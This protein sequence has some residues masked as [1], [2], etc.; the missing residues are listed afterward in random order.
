MSTADVPAPKQY[1]GVMVSSTFADLQKQREV[2]RRIIIAHGL[3]PIAMEHDSAKPEGDVLNS[4]LAMVRDCAAY[5]GIVGHTYGQIPVSSVRNPDRLS[6][7][8]LEFNFALSLK[9]P[10]LLFIMSDQHDVKPSDIERE[11]ETIQK[12]ERFRE[13]A[14]RSDAEPSMPRVYKVFSD[15][16]EFEAAAAQS[17]ASLRLYLDSAAGSNV[18]SPSPSEAESHAAPALDPIPRPPALYSEPAYI[19]SHKFVGRQNQIET[20]S[21]WAMPADSHAVLLFEAI[22]GA[23]KSMLTWE[24]T[25]RYAPGVR[26]DWAGYF[27]YSFY[28]RGATMVDFCRRGL[29]YMTGQNRADFRE[30]NVA[31][32][33]RLLLH[34]L[35]ARPWLVILD[36]LE[37][38]L[39]AYHR[40]DAAQVLDERA[41][42][43]DTI[44]RR[45]PCAATNPED[46]DLLRALASAGPSKLLLTSRLVPRALLNNSGQSIPGVVRERL[47]G[48]RPADAEALIRA[49]G[50]RGTS[51][52]IQHFLKSHCDCH[53]LVVGVLA[54]IINDYLPDRGHFNAWVDDPAYGGRLNLAALDLIQKRN[55]ILKAAL[56]ALSE[57][58][59]QLLSTLALLS[60]AVDYSTLCALNPHLPPAPEEVPVPVAPSRSATWRHLEDRT[61][62]RLE[63]EYEMFMLRRKEYE[64]SHASHL[65]ASSA[66]LEELTKT[67]S[68]LERR[69]LLQ[70]DTS[71]RRYDLH[72]VVRGIAA[73]GLGQEEKATYGQRVVD[74]FSQ[75]AQNP[76]ELAS[77][78]DDFEG[79]RHIV[80]TFFH[81][82][83]M[84]DA[85]NFIANSRFIG[86]MNFRFEAHNEILSLL[87]PFFVAG[88]SVM[89]PCLEEA[90]GTYFARRAAVSL[91][92][93]GALDDALAVLEAQLKMTVQRRVTSLSCTVLLEIA[94]TL[95]DKNL[96][97]LEDRVL[98]IAATLTAVTEGRGDLTSLH[99][100]RFRQLSRI[101]RMQEAEAEWLLLQEA[102]RRDAWIGFLAAH[103]R[104]VHLF[105]SGALTEGI[106]AEAEK[107]S[108]A[109][110]SA[111]S[112]RNLCALR[113]AWRAERGD[114]SGA[115]MDLQNAVAQ[116]RKVGVVDGRSEIFLT[117]ARYHLGRISDS[118]EVAEQL[119]ADAGPECQEYL[120]QLWLALGRQ[121]RATL[122]ARAAYEWAWAD[123][124][125]FVR[126]REL[127]RVRGIFRLLDSAP[128]RLTSFDPTKMEP[129]RW[130]GDAR[131]A[132]EAMHL[133]KDSEAKQRRL[134]RKKK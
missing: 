15:M 65:L 85:R 32:L 56:G 74:H 37:R 22:G 27:W 86:S 104:A 39:V 36:G 87:K 73:G 101:G 134:G 35:K 19:G 34:Q 24:W 83:R 72:P 62:A 51:S 89:P 132:I 45:H 128:P 100:A 59:R 46:D 92:R 133:R 127:D 40:F 112:I 129:L 6:L 3:M 102:V 84:R 23:G 108:A 17:V 55:H 82:G 70:Y 106:L 99:L 126:R 18:P 63:A 121:D 125:P 20:L 110:R 49:C 96:L 28:E 118:D 8:E 48:L 111:T 50:V 47:P 54:G 5:I 103:H 53:P 93:I 61:K 97:A 76:Y 12:L 120:A 116:A 115:E 42:V 30:K 114:W 77:A 78:L 107:L 7:T 52:D 29:V 33:T 109:A 75:Q 98:Q 4:S 88:W 16:H 80:K 31:E 122:H 60:E 43:E 38:V 95:G 21:D 58:A 2:L 25:T 117:L 10:I 91:R 131:R 26:A 94:S 69:G 64:E 67:V 66:A 1:A 79:A 44:A 123:G 124:E 9:R 71:A 130:E 119:S 90:K 14:K 68:D 13:R 57:K 81:M 11:S 113:G 105:S 41:G